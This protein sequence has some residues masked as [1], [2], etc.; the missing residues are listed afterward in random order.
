[1]FAVKLGTLLPDNARAFTSPSLLQVQCFG[2][3]SARLR[4]TSGRLSSRFFMHREHVT[5]VSGHQKRVLSEMLRLV[6]SL[7]WIFGV[8]RG[9]SPVMS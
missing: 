3:N 7:E 8:I 9:M 2:S 6:T 5:E 4:C 1:M